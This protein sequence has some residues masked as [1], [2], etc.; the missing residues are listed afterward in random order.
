M[1]PLICLSH[2]FLDTPRRL[3]KYAKRIP[4][5]NETL[6]NPTLL[7]IPLESHVLAPRY[8]PS[9]RFCRALLPLARTA[10]PKGL[11]DVLKCV[12]V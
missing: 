3:S 8:V 11:H 10:G 4:F 6:R 9:L 2:F 1:D 5:A 12:Q 7:P